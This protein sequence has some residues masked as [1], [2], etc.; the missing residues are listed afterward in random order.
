MTFGKAIELLK[1]GRLVR[2]REWKDVRW[3]LLVQGAV[4]K[5]DPGA[6]Y[7]VNLLRLGYTEGYSEIK[8]HIDIHI[9]EGCMQPGWTPTQ[10]DMLA[11]DWEL[12]EQ[13][14]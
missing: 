14:A 5:L 8:S 13:N 2:R 10:A 7:T 12:V 3:L 11:G 1:T 9:G 6:T 4:R